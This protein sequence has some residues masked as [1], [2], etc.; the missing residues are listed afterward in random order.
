MIILISALLFTTPAIAV[1]SFGGF[2]SDSG[3]SREPIAAN[4]GR[5]I[6]VTC[7]HY[8]RCAPM[9]G[10]ITPYH[11]IK[12]NSNRI[13][14]IFGKDYL[15][16]NLP[17][18][19]YAIDIFKYNDFGED[20][21]ASSFEVLIKENRTISIISESTN[22][23]GTSYSTY[24]VSNVDKLLSY[25]LLGMT[26]HKA[27]LNEPDLNSITETYLK[28]VSEVSI[29]EINALRM[30]DDEIKKM[31]VDLK[32]SADEAKKWDEA[33]QEENNLR[34]AKETTQKREAQI[35]EVNNQ[36]NAE[37]LEAKRQKEIED[38]LAKKDDATCKS[39]GAK[40]GTQAYI[41][42]RVSLVAGRQETADRQ[43]TIDVLEK[44]IEAL[45]S[46]IQLQAVAQSQA[47]E[48]DRRL[49]AEQYASEQ[50]FK[51]KQIEL[52]QAQLQTLQQEAQSAREARKWEAFR[53]LGQPAPSNQAAPSPFSSYRIDGRTYRCTD[54][55]GQV[56]C[57]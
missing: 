53:K 55:G 36:K 30:S 18:G 17:I 15:D 56:N 12:I 28:N 10:S 35:L 5:L 1:Q 48:R 20:S 39:Y 4:T 23:E 25:S 33:K 44:K 19:T 51:N 43:K 8:Q 21:L 26:W 22:F 16:I 13:A 57:R 54:I 49:S 6:L 3:Y 31:D 37:A 27:K 52:Q 11:Y 50:E 24:Q 34:V 41:Q 29:K 47:Q 32:R 42:C 38:A 46:Q 45:Q 7:P 14:T 9:F 2:G 40:K